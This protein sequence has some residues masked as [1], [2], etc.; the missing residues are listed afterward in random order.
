MRIW[1]LD[2]ICLDVYLYFS[3]I[4]TTFLLSHSFRLFGYFAWNLLFYL[5]LRSFFLFKFKVF[6]FIFSLVFLK[7]F[8]GYE[9]YFNIELNIKSNILTKRIFSWIK[10]ICK[11]FLIIKII[12]YADIK[13]S[14]GYI[15]HNFIISRAIYF[16]NVVCY[17]YYIFIRIYCF[18]KISLFKEFPS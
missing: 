12:S 14:I 9:S 16:I 3:Y 15:K 11:T 8:V 7:I 10:R 1:F 2:L 17:I 6:L 18:Y 4:F 13:R 5:S